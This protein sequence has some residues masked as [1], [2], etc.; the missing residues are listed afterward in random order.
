VSEYDSPWQE[1]IDV[2]FEPFV[3]FCYPK[4]HA[5]IDWSRGYEFLDKELHKIEPE[6][7]E[8]RRVVDKLVRVWRMDGKEEW[9]LVHIEV[10]S[11]EEA[12]FARRMYVYNYRLTDKYNRAVVSLAVLGDDRPTWR[13][14]SYRRALWGCS[15][16]F[17][18]PVVKLLDW[19]GREEELEQSQNPFALFVLAHLK[20]VATRG[21]DE[22]RYRWKVQLIRGLF[23]AG[24]KSQD[25][26]RL[27]RFMDWLLEL[28]QEL[29]QACREVVHKLQEEKEMPYVTSFERLAREEGL[30]EGREEG[31]EEGLRE[32]I[33]IALAVKF[34]EQGADLFREIE[35]IE[36]IATLQQVLNSIP[37]AETADEWRRLWT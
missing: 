19:V 10:Q 2:Y 11:Q 22:N 31:R 1:A 14:S 25:I 15:V 5:Q 17:Q 12:R 32:G 16:D 3:K 34:G 26:R 35:P 4:I 24:L 36:D 8:G 18:F 7:E 28:P 23:G 6:A 33:R 30:E 21:D 27:L 13:P 37:T 20:A 9:V 29:A